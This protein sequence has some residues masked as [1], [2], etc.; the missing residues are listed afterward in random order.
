MEVKLDGR[1]C[2]RMIDV[3]VYTTWEDFEALIRTFRFLYKR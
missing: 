1:K 3:Y 2:D